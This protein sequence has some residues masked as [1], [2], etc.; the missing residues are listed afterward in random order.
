MVVCGCDLE[1]YLGELKVYLPLQARWV[2]RRCSSY[3][4]FIRGEDIKH[5][6]IVMLRSALW[7]IVGGIRDEWKLVEQ[8]FYRS[9]D[10]EYAA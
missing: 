4:S 10:R 7:E 1:R 9:R 8:L 3:C 6:S 2:V 5:V